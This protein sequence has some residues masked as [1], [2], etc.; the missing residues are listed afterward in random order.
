[1]LGFSSLPDTPFFEATEVKRL[2]SNG[3]ADGKDTWIGSSE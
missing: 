2:A 1:M 3:G